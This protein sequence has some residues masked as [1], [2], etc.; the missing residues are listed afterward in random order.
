MQK[1]KPSRYRGVVLGDR[2]GSRREIG[3]EFD[4]E[5]GAGSGV[6]PVGVVNRVRNV[7]L[8]SYRSQ[9]A[10]FHASAHSSGW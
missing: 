3:Q 7:R 2:I 4:Y 1:R 10:L 5:F 9:N 8:P 6:Q